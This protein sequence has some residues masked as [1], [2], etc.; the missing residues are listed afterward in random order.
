MAPGAPAPHHPQ[1][2]VAL[3]IVLEEA[4]KY[5]PSTKAEQGR[6]V[7]GALGLTG[8][9]AMRKVKQLSGGEKARV[10]L[11]ALA[12]TPRT[13]L[14]LDEPTNHLDVPTIESLVKAVK[15][16]PGGVVVISHDREFCEELEPT[17]VATVRDGTLTMEER[18]LRDSDWAEDDITSG[19]RQAQV[20]GCAALAGDGVAVEAECA[21]PAAPEPEA[22]TPEAADAA[23]AAEAPKPLSRF[24]EQ[25]LGR[26]ESDVEALEAR[27]REIEGRIAEYSAG[28]DVG[29]LEA[30]TREQGEVQGEYDRKSER[31][32]ELA[33]RHAATA[34]VPA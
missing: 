28:G 1:E 15:E 2:A 18:D 4:R 19:D 24:E 29:A 3:D 31:W 17:H 14:L 11:A 33:D 5:D 12:M 25:E 32:M 8:E 34:A 20:D 9:K 26:L 21:A 30:A 10:A 13:C 27:L 23:E 22:A 7:M 6:A 16:F